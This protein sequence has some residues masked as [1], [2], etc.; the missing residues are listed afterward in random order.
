MS[1]ESANLNVRM[2]RALLTRLRQ[3]AENDRRSINSTILVL[4]ERALAE[5]KKKGQS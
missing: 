5:N 3:Y 2:P 1:E 4:L